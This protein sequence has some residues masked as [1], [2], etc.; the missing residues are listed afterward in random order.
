[1]YIKTYSD[2]CH[3]SI[4]V[5]LIRDQWSVTSYFEPCEL[6]TYW[7]YKKSIYSLLVYIV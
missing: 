3:V 4:I 5:R 7:Y 6:I 1:M 2:F